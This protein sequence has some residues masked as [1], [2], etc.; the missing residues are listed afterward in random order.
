MQ[1]TQDQ[2]DRYREDGFVVVEQFV[3]I[4]E[5]ERVREHFARCFDHEWE[6]GLRPDEVNYEPGITPPDRTRQMCNLWK[7]DRTI[8]ATTLAARHAEFA[9]RLDGAPG[10]RL[11]IDNAVWKPGGGKAVLAHQ[12]AAYQGAFAPANLTT[13]WMALDET[14]ADSGTI[15]YAR[16]SHLWGRMPMGGQF[17]APD[18]WTA[19]MRD[20]APT[21]VVDSVEWVPIEVPPGGVAFHAG[22]TFHGSP[23]NERADR[24]RRAIISHMMTTET[25][26]SPDVVHDVYSRYRRPGEDEI[27]EAFF[28]VLWREDGYR[29]P[30][31]D[32]YAAAAV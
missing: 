8:A 24:E 5:V 19:Y 29:T 13:C 11:F 27:D 6:T 31:L 7:S 30:F 12:D 26:W 3:P 15:Y 32:G 21:E 22:W 23:P 16:G 18:D 10:M 2:I 25:T 20:V 4:D 9:A 1:P 17:H 28:P 14:H